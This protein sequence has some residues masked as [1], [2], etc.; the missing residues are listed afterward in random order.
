VDSAGTERKPLPRLCF[1]SFTWP[2]ILV[3]FGC[4]AVFLSLPLAW[5][6]GRWDVLLGENVTMVSLLRLSLSFESCNGILDSCVVGCGCACLDEMGCVM[7]WD[8]GFI[9]VS[10]FVF[11]RVLIPYC[12]LNIL[13]LLGFVDVRFWAVS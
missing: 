10:V 5:S 13:S 2:Y 3:L 8:E 9:C 4:S 11:M 12:Y 1:F 6:V 7:G